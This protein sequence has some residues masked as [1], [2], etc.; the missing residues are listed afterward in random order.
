[1]Q[2]AGQENYLLTQWFHTR[3]SENNRAYDQSAKNFSGIH[4][5]RLTNRSVAFKGFALIFEPKQSL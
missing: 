2:Q 4:P 1:M 5:L 3:I